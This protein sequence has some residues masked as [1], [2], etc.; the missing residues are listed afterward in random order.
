MKTDDEIDDDCLAFAKA[1]ADKG[2]LAASPDDGPACRSWPEIVARALRA[3]DRRARP[4]AGR[5]AA[6]ARIVA[7]VSKNY[8]AETPP[9]ER[10]ILAQ[11]FEEV[12]LRNAS[13]GFILDTW[14]LSRVGTLHGINETIVATFVERPS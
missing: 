5:L 1:E 6:G 14:Q 13:R 3:L 11:R 4:R 2:T 9:N 12:I 7:E 8:D 10:G